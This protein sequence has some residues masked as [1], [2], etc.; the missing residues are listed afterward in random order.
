MSMDW[1]PKPLDL[2]TI[3][4]CFL[5]LFVFGT[6]TAALQQ[7]AAA[8]ALRRRLARCSAGPRCFLYVLFS[9]GTLNGV[10]GLNGR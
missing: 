9:E 8:A 2:Y 10:Q 5:F 4:C 6:S 3:F 1:E 7:H